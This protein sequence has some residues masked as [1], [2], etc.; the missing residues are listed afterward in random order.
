VIEIGVHAAADDLRIDR[1]DE[2]GRV[3]EIDE[4]DGCEL[5]LQTVKCRTRPGVAG[6]ALSGR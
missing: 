1:A 5:A 2:A 6:V 3:D 4:K